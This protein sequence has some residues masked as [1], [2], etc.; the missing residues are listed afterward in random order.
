MSVT[1]HIVN[2]DPFRL[3]KEYRWTCD[4]CGQAGTR[5]GIMTAVSGEAIAH[6]DICRYVD[7]KPPEPEDNDPGLPTWPPSS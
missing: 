4:E 5:S 1:I 7:G 6:L 2:G 3:A